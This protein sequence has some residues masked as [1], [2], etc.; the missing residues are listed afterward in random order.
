MT[1]PRLVEIQPRE[2]FQLWVKFSDGSEGVS[3]L[4]DVVGK[5]VFRLWDTPGEF[6]KARIGD[7]GE[8]VWADNL[9]VCPDAIYFEVTGQEPESFFRAAEATH[10]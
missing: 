4:S 10:A 3:D 8:I 7:S 6:E 9:D 2:N 5:G 1:L